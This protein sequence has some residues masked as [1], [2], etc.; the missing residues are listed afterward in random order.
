[1]FSSDQF[2]EAVKAIKAT[3][4]Q[5]AAS[6]RPLG[7]LSIDRNAL[8]SGLFLVGLLFVN[9]ATLNFFSFYTGTA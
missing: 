7:L 2:S 1:M 5:L 6:D 4:A 9:E 3:I 8:F